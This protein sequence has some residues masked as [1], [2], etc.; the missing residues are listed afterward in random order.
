[1]LGVGLISQERLPMK[2]VILVTGGGRGIG[3]AISKIAAA[4][5]YAVAIN[6]LHD[7]ASA[8]GLA[9]AI[10]SDGGSACLVKGDVAIEADVAR[11]FQATE[12]TL[13]PLYGLVN[14]A[15]ITG[16]I[17]KFISADPAMIERVFRTNV[18]G[19]MNCCRVALQCFQRSGSTGVIV[20]VSSIAAVTGSPNEYVHYAASKS[21]IETF[22]LGL[23]REVAAEN[24]RVCAVAPGSTLTDIHAAAG[25]PDRPARVAPRIPLGRLAA[26]DEIAEPI[27]WLLSDSASYMTGTTIRC[28]GGL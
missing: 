8:K 11:M 23:A 15:G 4:R 26:P 7:D 25:E 20:N 9:A 18:L 24:I 21:A 10:N 28:A 14:N 22:T 27:V 5:G 6:Y 1:M 17:G 12:S 3:A 2:K 16:R 19:T 13:G